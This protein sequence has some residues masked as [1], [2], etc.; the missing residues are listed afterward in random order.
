[1]EFGCKEFS[2]NF[3]Q[4]ILVFCAA[5]VSG[6]NKGFENGWLRDCFKQE[7]HCCC[8]WVWSGGGLEIMAMGST[9]HESPLA[10]KSGHFQTK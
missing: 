9:H 8:L 3:S 10:S 5:S 1:M 2:I 4:K 7:R 6:A